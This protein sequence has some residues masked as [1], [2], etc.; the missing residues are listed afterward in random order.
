[1]SLGHVV[2]KDEVNRMAEDDMFA[3]IHVLGSVRGY[4]TIACSN[5]VRE[6]ERQELEQFQFGELSTA[7]AIARLET[8]V[9][10]TGR[11]LSSGRFALSR[12]L[13]GRP[14]DIG[15]PTVE[16]VT[17]VLEA[18]TY[19]ACAGML[20][21]L[22]SDAAFW[23][24][25][26]SDASS[27][28]Q[29]RSTV[30]PPGSVD[31][32]TMQLF[33]LWRAACR[34]GAIGV[35]PDADSD[36]LLRFVALLHPSD[37]RTCRWGVGLL[38]LSTTA[39]ICSVA[40]G[41]QLQGPRDVMRLASADAWHC[42]AEGDYVE[43]RVASGLQ[44]LPSMAEVASNGRTRVHA[45]DADAIGGDGVAR[46]AAAGDRRR[47][48]PLR[49]AAIGSAVLSTLALAVAWSAWRRPVPTSPVAGW[50]S[51]GVATKDPPTTVAAPDSLTHALPEP[52]PSPP[53]AAATGD[54][55]ATVIPPSTPV[56]PPGPPPSLVPLAP[57][58][59]ASSSDA[60]GS[61]TSQPPNSAETPAEDSSTPASDSPS[62]GGATGGTAETGST[63]NETGSSPTS[64]PASSAPAPTAPTAPPA[65]TPAEQLDRLYA[66]MMDRSPR[67]E[68]DRYG[69]AVEAAP[70]RG[71]VDPPNWEL[72]VGS[73]IEII[74]EAIVL[75]ATLK[76]DGQPRPQAGA[77]SVPRGHDAPEAVDGGFISKATDP[78]DLEG[79]RLNT[80]LGEKWRQIL[81]QLE[82]NLAQLQGHAPKIQ[83]LKS[84]FLPFEDRI[85]GLLPNSFARLPSA[86]QKRVKNL[87][88]KLMDK[89]ARA[90]EQAAIES[91]AAENAA[92]GK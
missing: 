30:P 4:S 5:G 6:T 49:R 3:D 52:A 46:G 18:S 31:L 51:E 63:P 9:L 50:A 32:A 22:A 20:A 12:M 14:D 11:P 83:D 62:G 58:P 76:R 54:S 21:R 60:G 59:S 53:V 13:P 86:E 26:R 77:A 17:V 56:P 28:T 72:V 81:G 65:P 74:A 75:D 87:L 40:S 67:A 25:V 7:D 80:E 84:F 29:I 35:V 10:M 36:A 78:R 57:S 82:L 73:W 33:D 42:G 55:A 8:H 89:R 48:S 91:E 61:A 2:A 1:V 24:S 70:N 69:S 16:V 88:E 66:Q 71:G 39:D 37:R 27:G 68:I 38:S 45:G 23:R 47:L 43:F 41:V 19:D 90:K 85:D 34:S 44:S 15:R 79:L 64:S 92:E